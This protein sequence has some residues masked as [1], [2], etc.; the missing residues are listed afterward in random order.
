MGF[1]G[2]AGREEERGR[3]SSRPFLTARHSGKELL[4]GEKTVWQRK[5][6]EK[7]YG[8]PYRVG[9]ALPF[10]DA[11]RSRLKRLDRDRVRVAPILVNALRIN[12]TNRLRPALAPTALG[13]PGPRLSFQHRRRL[14]LACRGP[15]TARHLPRAVRFRQLLCLAPAPARAPVTRQT[16]DERTPGQTLDLPGPGTAAPRVALQS[17]PS[18]SGRIGVHASAHC[19]RRARALP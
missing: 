12:G 1:V 15:P 10:L 17:C 3:R 16:L 19:P 4:R 7:W 14:L 13:P 9:G 18:W 2:K 5:R 6:S 11:L 8:R